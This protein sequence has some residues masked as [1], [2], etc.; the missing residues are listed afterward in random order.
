VVISSERMRRDCSRDRKTQTRGEKQSH[1]GG[2]ER[3]V[4]SRCRT[5]CNA[6]SGELCTA[7]GGFVT[8]WWLKE[9]SDGR[10]RWP[11]DVS[12][13]NR[14]VNK[15]IASLLDSGRVEGST[16]ETGRGGPGGMDGQGPGAAA[17]AHAECPGAQRWLMQAVRRAESRRVGTLARRAGQLVR[18]AWASW[19]LAGANWGC[20]QAAVSGPSVRQRASSLS[21]VYPNKTSALHLGSVLARRPEVQTWHHFVLK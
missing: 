15:Q 12:Q 8:S 2:M 3:C 5:G 6:G 10:I 18:G 13:F 17:R 9:K 20:S 14:S 21:T 4:V 11:V 16:V 1:K 7:G 19:Q